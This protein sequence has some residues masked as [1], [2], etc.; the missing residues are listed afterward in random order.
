MDI[1]R[2]TLLAAL[3]SLAVLSQAPASAETPSGVLPPTAPWAPGP[4]EVQPEV[5]RQATRLIEAVGAWTSSGGNVAAARRRAAAAGFDPDLADALHPLLGAADAAAVQVADAQYGGILPSTA[6]VLVVVDQWRME[7]GGLLVPGG[8]TV[9][10]RQERA[11]QGWKVVDVTPARFPLPA[12]DLSA[13]A[14]AVLASS[15]IRLPH[16]ARADVLAGRIHESLLHVLLALGSNHSLEISVL[17]SGHPQHVFGTSRTSDHSRGRAVDIWAVDDKPIV[18]P[19]NRDLASSVM[20]FAVR[21]GAYNVGGPVL[22]PGTQYFSD[23][24][25]RDHVHL[26][27]A[28]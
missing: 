5:K 25:H 7:S 4:G 12:R 19:S 10:V 27:F 9:E 16:A 24:T 22:L 14:R 15:R 8:T 11:G 20:R 2:R 18:R 26:G 1:D 6:S 21:N 13:P 3:A 17:Q 23:L 28:A